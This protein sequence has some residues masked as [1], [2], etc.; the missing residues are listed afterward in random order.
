MAGGLDPSGADVDF[1]LI[2]NKGGQKVA[3]Q[4]GDLLMALFVAEINGWE[5][6]PERYRM[7][8]G[9]YYGTV[10]VAARVIEIDNIVRLASSVDPRSDPA[11]STEKIRVKVVD[12]ELNFQGGD[13]IYAVYSPGVS[14]LP[15]ADWESLPKTT[16]A[17]AAGLFMC[18]LSGSVSAATATNAAPTTGEVFRVQPG[19]AFDLLGQ[20]TMYN[21][22]R[23]S[24]PSAAVG[25]TIHYTCTKSYEHDPEDETEADDEFTI[26]GIDP[27]HLLASLDGFAEMKSLSAPQ[28]GGSAVTGIKWLGTPCV[29]P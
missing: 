14:A 16:P 24:L 6:L 22:Y 10:N 9:D 13:K 17:A 12:G 5:I 21:P 19:G 27:L 15:V 26:I 28:G 3:Y 29:T 7:I 20:R 18:T 11:S 8:R 4:A 1:D 23:I 25:T 2:V